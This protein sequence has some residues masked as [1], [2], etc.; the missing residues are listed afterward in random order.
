MNIS[1]N[2]IKEV[3]L[4]TI[5]LINN[6]FLKEVN[7]IF[8][9]ISFV[10]Y[11]FLKFKFIL[12][13]PYF[14]FLGWSIYLLPSI[15]KYSNIIKYE[16]SEYINYFIIGI[17][18]FS[19][20]YEKFSNKEIIF[21]NFYKI[22]YQNLD[23]LAFSCFFYMGVFNIAFKLLNYSTDITKGISLI[24]NQ[25]ITASI[26]A[27]LVTIA[28]KDIKEAFLKSLLVFS[29]FIF[30]NLFLL[31]NTSRINILQSGLLILTILIIG[32]NKFNFNKFKV[33]YGFG[34]I[35]SKY[36]FLFLC[37]LLASSKRVITGGDSIIVYNASNLIQ[38]LKNN[39]KFEPLMPI[40]NGLLVLFPKSLLPFK[41]PINFNSSAWIINNIYQINPE[42]I[43][44]GTSGTLV[45]ASYI[46]GGISGVIL[47]F[48][49][50][51]VITVYLQSLI[52]SYFFLAFYIYFLFNLSFSIFRM[53][54]TFFLGP[55]IPFLITTFF[56]KKLFKKY[57]YEKNN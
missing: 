57:I 32:K 26:F 16:V 30:T 50:I 2:I 41:K 5:L 49:I 7:P 39:H 40:H 56:Y 3:Y 8:T 33:F 23:K 17:F 4:V 44:Y 52:D 13:S 48:S 6:T 46:Y 42:I 22:N 29:Y 34:E 38:F 51:A 28:R 47:V 14:Y 45:G 31:T 20:I 55:F 25:T 1:T 21:K 43:P 10:V 18:F 37:S 35:I 11:F 12:H 54:E 9:Y 19:L 53:D 15:N 36:T 24:L 27:Y